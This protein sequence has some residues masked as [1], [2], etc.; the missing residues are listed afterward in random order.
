MWLLLSSGAGSGAVGAGEPGRGAGGAR[1]EQC[2]PGA[3]VA[4]A[5]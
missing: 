5:G 3:A 2:G 4:A 1:G